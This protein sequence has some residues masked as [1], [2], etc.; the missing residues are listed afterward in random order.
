MGKYEAVGQVFSPDPTTYPINFDKYQL[1]SI[2]S[3]SQD[4]SRP[5][6]FQTGTITLPDWKPTR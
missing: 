6:A 5:V 2:S 1:I 3:T 4:L